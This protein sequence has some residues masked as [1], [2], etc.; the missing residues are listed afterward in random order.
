[1]IN[2][3]LILFVPAV[4][5]AFIVLLLLMGLNNKGDLK[6]ANVQ[7][8]AIP[9]FQL[10]ALQADTLLTEALFTETTG[11][12]DTTNGYKLLNVWASWCIVCKTEHPFLL[13][14]AS[15]GIEIVGLNYRDQPQAATAIL[16]K[17]GNPYQQVIFDPTGSLALDLGVVGTPETYLV[18]KQGIIIGRFNGVLTPAVWETY[19]EPL[20]TK[21]SENG[22]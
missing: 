20:I 7:A 11:T 9:P 3:K 13:E 2:K 4:S 1:M 15:Q 19:F 22:V 5:V 6:Q 16:I 14:L 17:T 18:N 12:K 21:I 10:N 8:R